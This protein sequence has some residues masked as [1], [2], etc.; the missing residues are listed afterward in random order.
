VPAYVPTVAE[1]EAALKQLHNP[2]ALRHNPLAALDLVHQ[3]VDAVQRVAN[4]TQASLPWIY[5]YELAALLRERIEKLQ[6]P[7]AAPHDQTIQRAAS[8]PQLYAQILRLRYLDDCSWQQVAQSVGLAAGHIQNK[9]KRPALQRLLGEL[10]DQRNLGPLRHSTDSDA[11]LAQEQRLSGQAKPGARAHITNLPAPGEFIGRRAEVENVI[12]K[13]RRRRM[14]II[15]ISGVGGVGKSA[16]AKHI[17]WQALEE[18]MVDAVIWLCAKD[19]A[20]PIPGVRVAIGQPGLRSLNDLFETTARVLGASQVPLEPDARRLQALDML[21]SGRFPNGI[22]III[23]NYET[24]Q[25]EEQERLVAFLFE[26]LPY[27]SQ[28]LITSRHEEHLVIVQSHILPTKIQ[29]ERMSREDAIACLDYFLSLHSP[30]LVTSADV[31]EQIIALS[32]QIPLAMLWLL[33]QLRY[34]ARSQIETIEEIRRRHGEA[35]ALLSYIFDFSYALLEAQPS[36]RSVLHAISAFGETVAFEP[37]A[38]VAGLPQAD[39]EH[40]LLLLQRL[41]LI[42]REEQ[43]GCPRYGLLEL[44]RS[45]VAGHIS[46]ARR[47][48]LLLRAGAYYAAHPHPDDRANI[49]PLLE[50]A[51]KERQYALALELFDRLT[52]AQFVESDTQVQDCA[53]YGAAIVA[54]A[55]ALGDDRR[56]DWYEIFALCWPLVLRHDMLEARLALERL[57]ER[58]QRNAWHDN[59]A[60]ACSTLG[61]VFNDLGTT[62]ASAGHDTGAFFETAAAFLRQAAALWE[63]LGRRDWLAVAM[64]RLGTVARQLG[65]FDRALDYYTWTAALYDTLGNHVGRASV[66]GRRGYT[67]L[68]RYRAQG[69]GDP[70]EIEQLLVEALQLNERLGNRWGIAANSLRYAEF[71]ELRGQPERALAYATRARTLFDII[72]EPHRAHQAAHLVAHLQ[73]HYR[74][75]QARSDPR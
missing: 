65:D 45:Y 40:A 29:L 50:W 5:G 53:S 46:E 32:A 26:E 21:S 10:L 7:P 69:R 16:L 49:T 28:A 31:K 14:P 24:L 34:A 4:R 54:A 57:L 19:R 73:A 51:L 6:T 1:L 75:Q 43:A 17:G 62:A 47:Y 39:V 44:A 15:E 37:L 22:L 25:P 36:A 38:A 27:P 9:L 2:E 66:L 42:T 33:G 61:L 59:R 63:D 60:L 71:L 11:A 13:L 18:R 12:G 30:P 3:R 56:A 64:G 67:L 70:Q 41:S 68:Q 55:R 20:L 58:A 52:A 35:S 72:P 8:R 23:D 74:E 48:D